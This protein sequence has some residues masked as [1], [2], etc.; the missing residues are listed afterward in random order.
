MG[1]MEPDGNYIV[2]AHNIYLQ[3]AYDHGIY[4]G[5]CVYSAG[6]GYID[7]GGILFAQAQGRQGMCGSAHGA[8]DT[9]CRG[10]ADRVDLPS[11]LSGACCLL[12]VL[13]PLL[14]DGR[15]AV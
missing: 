3:A 14:V 6:C 8:S 5:R 2:H 13:S 4:V 1:I 9:F 15:R 7:P 11:L 12:L 10:G